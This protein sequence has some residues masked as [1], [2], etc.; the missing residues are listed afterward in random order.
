VGVITATALALLFAV[1]PGATLT[2]NVRGTVTTETAP[3]GGDTGNTGS[4]KCFPD[5]PCDPPMG[6]VATSGTKTVTTTV[7]TSVSFSRPG[8][9]AV[10]VRAVGGSFALH[11]TPASYRISLPASLGVVSPA[12]VRVPRTGT[13]RLHL[14]VQPTP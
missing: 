3:A 11:L 7:T 6:M 8:H 2:P 14:V 1:S 5:E 10:H 4:I 9:R 13:V 12:T